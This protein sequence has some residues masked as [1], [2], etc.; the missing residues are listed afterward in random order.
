MDTTHTPDFES[1]MRRILAETGL[2]TQVQLADLLGIRK[3]SI[4]DAKR[5][6][7]VPAEWLLRLFFKHNLNPDYILNGDP[8]L[9]Y[10]VPTGNAREGMTIE[11]LRAQVRAELAKP[12]TKDDAFGEFRDAY[13]DAEIRFPSAT[14]IKMRMALA[15][16]Q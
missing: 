4:S 1:A 11:Q 2:K 7:S 3:S 12:R 14:E 8:A 6:G 9:K 13:P 10:L 15:G 16:K 5:R